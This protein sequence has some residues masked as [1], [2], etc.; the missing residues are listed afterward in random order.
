MKVMVVLISMLILITS[1]KPDMIPPN[2]SYEQNYPAISPNR[3]GIQD[4]LIITV[5][6]ASKNFIRYWEMQVLNEE[7]Q[8]VYTKNSGENLDKLK[9]KLFMKRQNIII[10]NEYVWDGKDSNGILLDDGKY[11]YK[12]IVMDNKKNVLDTENIGLGVVYIDTLR[13]K[14][15]YQVINPVFSPNND[16]NKDKMEIKLSISPDETQKKYKELNGNDWICQIEDNAG[17]LVKTITVN[18]GSGVNLS[19]SWDGTDK[20]G[21]TVR[22]GNYMFRLLS[23]DK[24]GNLWQSPL[25]NIQVSTTENP[26]KV[27]VKD[28]AFSPNKDKIKDTIA[29]S[30]LSSDTNS[31]ESW[32]LSILSKKNK[33]I[34]TISGTKELLSSVFWD[35]LSD[36][37][38]LAEEDIYYAL[39]KI[40]SVNGNI[41]K[42]ESDYFALDLTPP[43]GIISVNYEVFSPDGN[44]RK[45]FITINQKMSKENTEWNAKILDAKNTVKRSYT[46]SA[47]TPEE[48]SFF[49]LDQDNKKLED[50]TYY[51]QVSSTDLAGNYYESPKK[52]IVIFTKKESINVLATEKAISPDMNGVSDVQKYLINYISY[53]TNN[54]VTDWEISVRD[55]DDNLVFN[56]A[57]EGELPKVYFWDGEGNDGKTLKDGEYS[58]YLTVNTLHGVTTVIKVP[59]FSL[60]LTPPEIVIEKDKKIFSPD[61]DGIDD[62][63]TLNFTKVY[64]RSGI[65]D[66]EVVLINPYTTKAYKT[67]TGQGAPTAALVWDG[68]GDDKSEV[69]SAEDYVIRLR[70]EDNVGNILE[71]TFD[72]IWTD[73]LIIKLDDGRL[74]IRVSS[75]NFKP[76]LAVMTDNKKN[77]EV[78]DLIARAL[79]KYPTH[80]VLL[81]GH[82]NPYRAN[83][84]EKNS[85]A[86]SEN[87]AITVQKELQK[88]GIPVSSLTP[89]G[90]GYSTPL[91]PYREG[92]TEDEKNAMA[93]NRRV[94]FYLSK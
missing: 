46:W 80:K 48:L 4:R 42:A 85:Q 39:L 84:N 54:P 70:A 51:Y 57:K 65:K 6:L 25:N 36:K 21:N 68:K 52:K 15:E 66:W 59:D 49:G 11:Y 34:K 24:A 73:I 29:F 81:E 40:I 41:S 60:D 67:F 12:F 77:K 69:G 9:K 89:V 30:L 47:N 45:D 83:M 64:D 91:I 3:D 28:R 18:D 33:V 61:G 78:L 14:A 31:I 32:S 90:K 88:R 79:K 75:I 26:V 72:P 56:E 62:T 37:G 55:K 19:L 76:E 38:T 92:I 71:K 2:A 44:G 35:G 13:S 23:S 93:I 5:D 53:T 87:R 10:P 50:G 94:E 43:Q 22:D 7:K 74:K 8:I 27:T 82:V 86:L 17:T 1:C 20:N 63:V 58:S 16:G